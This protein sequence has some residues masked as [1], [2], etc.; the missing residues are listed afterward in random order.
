MTPET[1]N[2]ASAAAQTGSRDMSLRD[3]SL[4]AENL[5]Q[6]QIKSSRNVAVEAAISDL[7]IDVAVEAAHI[8]SVTAR[9]FVENVELGDLWAAEHSLGVAIKHLREAAAN[10]RAWQAIKASA[11]EAWR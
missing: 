2:P 3:S 9:H 6:A 7:T 11:K 10:F 5:P 1:A 8:A 4:I